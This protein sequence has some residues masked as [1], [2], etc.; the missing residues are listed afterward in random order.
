MTPFDQFA[1]VDNLIPKNNSPKTRAKGSKPKQQQKSSTTARKPRRSSAALNR[2]LPSQLL[3]SRPTVNTA[4]AMNLQRSGSELV[5]DVAIINPGNWAFQTTV[6]PR[7]ALFNVLRRLSTCYE[8]YHVN[9]LSF[10]YVPSCSSLTSGQLCMFLDY[11]PTD[12]NTGMDFDTMVQNA[13]A[14]ISQIAARNS[15]AYRPNMTVLPSHRYF[16]SE[17]LTPDRLND[18]CRLWA[19]TDGPTAIPLVGKIYIHYN[20]TFFNQEMPPQ[21]MPVS[22]RTIT[23]LASDNTSSATHPMGAVQQMV[24][25]ALEQGTTTMPTILKAVGPVNDM[26][27]LGKSFSAF[28]HAGTA[29]LTHLLRSTWSVY[30]NYSP[31]D[32]APHHKMGGVFPPLSVMEGDDIPAATTVYSWNTDPDWIYVTCV[33]IVIVR[34]GTAAQAITYCGFHVLVNDGWTLTD[35]NSNT[36]QFPAPIT[37]GNYDTATLQFDAH[38]HRNSQADRVGALA[39]HIHAKDVNWVSVPTF[40]VVC[41]TQENVR[42]EVMIQPIADLPN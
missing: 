33:L 41:S 17:A 29:H 7:K 16:N 11:D 30:E 40:T 18:C 34:N 5:T 19:K 12:D 14:A 8:L 2:P 21:E 1:S 3:R 36:L 32:D 25:T 15:I 38:L 26:I 24:S 13:G 39:F 20:V 35:L 10:E 9:S 23:T 31:L 4:Q 37:N 22:F 28:D 42:S 27:K 6:N